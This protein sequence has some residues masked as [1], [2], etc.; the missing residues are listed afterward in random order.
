MQMETE[1]G[2]GLLDQFTT[3]TRPRASILADSFSRHHCVQFCAG[4]LHLQGDLTKRKQNLVR[5]TKHTPCST[6][7]YPQDRMAT[8]AAAAAA[9]KQL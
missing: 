9:A 8:S 2:R 7:D 1:S 3:S 5:E 6:K 4:K